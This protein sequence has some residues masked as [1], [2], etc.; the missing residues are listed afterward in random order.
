MLRMKIGALLTV[1]AVGCG[2]GAFQTVPVDGLLT[3]EGKPVANVLVTF[4]P[5]GGEGVDPNNPGKS[6]V[7]KT[8]AEGRFTLTTYKIG[9]GAIVGQHT[10]RVDR[11]YDP[12]AGSDQPEFA[13]SGKTT[14]VTVE[15]NT[16][17]VK[18]EL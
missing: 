2:G 11:E 5:K 3:C 16:S 9:D 10:V 17:E 1:F 13:C 15:A 8:D 18:I 14:E 7:G 4:T 12:E 6:A